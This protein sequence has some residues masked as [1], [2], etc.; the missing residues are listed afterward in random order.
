MQ[1]Y[2]NLLYESYVC[3]IWP[4]QG[5]VMYHMHSMFY[6]YV[7]SVRSTHFTQM[8]SLWNPTILSNSLRIKQFVRR[9][10]FHTYYNN[11]EAR[12]CIMLEECAKTRTTICLMDH[13]FQHFRQFLAV[14]QT[15]VLWDNKWMSIINLQWADKEIAPN[16]TMQLG[17]HLDVISWTLHFG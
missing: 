2:L 13:Q 9:I 17:L 16:C 11:Q 7:Y 15:Q 8:H 1:Q 3:F 5:L 6:F 10:L 14:E 4:F 12:N